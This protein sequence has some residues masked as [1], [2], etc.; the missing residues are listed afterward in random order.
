MSNHIS[1]VP[2]TLPPELFTAASSGDSSASHTVQNSSRRTP[3]VSSSGS[4]RIPPQVPPKI[5]QSPIRTEFTGSIPASL[6]RWDVAPQD[7]QAF[8]N[9]FRG[10]DTMNK[11][12]IDGMIWIPAF[13]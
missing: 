7:K 11:G 5:L 4:G 6:D 10:I 12:Y 8:D 2:A 9:A 1:A 13:S 3:S